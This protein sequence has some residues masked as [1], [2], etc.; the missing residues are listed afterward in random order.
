MFANS[1][2]ILSTMTEGMPDISLNNG[3]E[4]LFWANGAYRRTSVES[5][6]E[7]S[8]VA[9]R[10]LVTELNISFREPESDGGAVMVLTNPNAFAV[11]FT[12]ICERDDTKA[13]IAF[14]IEVP[15]DGY[16]ELGADDGWENGFVSGDRCSAVI[17]DEPIRVIKRTG[18]KASSVKTDN[19]VVPVTERWIVD[20]GPAVLF[21]ETS[22]ES[23]R[24]GEFGQGA[25][26]QAQQ[27]SDA[28]LR[29]EYPDAGYLLKDLLRKAGEDW[30]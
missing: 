26:V 8:P 29:V 9:R 7:Q 6:A 16:E 18:S 14:I 19:F 15:G 13:K 5:M 17:D 12:M 23:R 4:R 25:T 24:I 28:W 11:S 22:T 27:I 20:K 10:K 1:M 21:S 2:E 30:Q 3:A